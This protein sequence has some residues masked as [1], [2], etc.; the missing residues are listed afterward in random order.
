MALSHYPS[1]M[2]HWIPG[3]CHIPGNVEADRLAEAAYHHPIREGI[4]LSTSDSRSLLTTY[5]AGLC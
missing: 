3:Y 1:V 2:F 5:S 4:P